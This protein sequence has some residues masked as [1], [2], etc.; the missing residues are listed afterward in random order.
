MPCRAIVPPPALGGRAWEASCRT[1]S[2]EKGA[3]ILEAQGPTLGTQSGGRCHGSLQSLWGACGGREEGGSLGG[4]G[5]SPSAE[6]ASSPVPGVPGGGQWWRSSL[7]RLSGFEYTRLRLRVD[8]GP[9]AQQGF[10]FSET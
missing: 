6:S 9:A 5:R 2:G 1:G 4:R 3:G 10:V 7:K 8:P